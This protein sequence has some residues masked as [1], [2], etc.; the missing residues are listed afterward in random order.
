MFS[1]H[2]S[3]VRSP[4]RQSSIDSSVT[5]SYASDPVSESHGTTPREVYE[6][7]QTAYSSK[8]TSVFTLRSRSNTAASTAPSLL[9]LSHP[10][11]AEHEPA[12]HDSTPSLRHVGSMSQIEPS[13]SVS[14]RSL[15]RGK[16]GKRLSE[17]VPSS[18]D[19]SHYKDVG[20]RSSVLHK[21]RRPH[22]SSG[23]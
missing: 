9:S 17:M 8:R 10:E 23:T 16:K 20:K 12:V 3:D 6:Q 11:M 2:K 13:G 1:F 7:P 18:I 15:F 21:G 4:I 19:A 5:V 22:E 14:K